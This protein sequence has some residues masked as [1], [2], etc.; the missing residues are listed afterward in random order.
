M[1]FRKAEHLSSKT[2]EIYQTDKNILH[3]L[4]ITFE[5]DPHKLNTDKTL[6][7]TLLPLSKIM[8][9]K[10]LQKHLKKIEME[11]KA[12]LQQFVGLFNSIELDD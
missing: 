3:S 2:L 4:P 7:Y 12:L 5:F 6:H 10:L 1:I 11:E 9:R 8:K